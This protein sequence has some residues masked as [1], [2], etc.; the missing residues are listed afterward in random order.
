MAPYNVPQPDT[1]GVPSSPPDSDTTSNNSNESKKIK[2]D[3]NYE[4][5]IFRAGYTNMQNEYIYNQQRRNALR[6]QDDRLSITSTASSVFSSMDG[7]P[8]TPSPDF[9]QSLSQT[10]SPLFMGYQQSPADPPPLRYFE[11]TPDCQSSVPN[12]ASD[13]H[14]YAVD[15]P[16]HSAAFPETESNSN[17]P[18]PDRQSDRSR[19][20]SD[21]GNSTIPEPD[22]ISPLCMNDWFRDAMRPEFVETF[23]EAIARIETKS[24]LQKDRYLGMRFSELPT[25]L[26]ECL[27]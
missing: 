5:M 24:A 16:T 8:S 27:T 7:Y 11:P 18:E 4:N 10:S 21:S 6:M 23:E 13:E 9:R 22:E 25:D 1:Y 12:R 3:S 26:G 2:Y 19:I 15:S 14:N 20:R 17:G